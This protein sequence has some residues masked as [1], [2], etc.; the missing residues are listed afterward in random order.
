MREKHD[1]LLPNVHSF[2]PFL[3]LNVVAF[4]D[5]SMEKKALLEIKNSLHIC[6]IKHFFG[7]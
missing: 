4:D 2:V 6:E 7:T 5:E 1:N 3:L